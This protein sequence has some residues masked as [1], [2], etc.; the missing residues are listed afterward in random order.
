MRL[1]SHSQHQQQQQQQQTGS[2]VLS[3][4]ENPHRSAEHQENAVLP[5]EHYFGT[6]SPPPPVAGS[7]FTAGDTEVAEGEAFGQI[8]LMQHALTRPQPQSRQ[9]EHGAASSANLASRVFPAWQQQQ[10]MPAVQQSRAEVVVRKRRTRD[11]NFVTS[12][13]VFGRARSARTRASSKRKAS[14]RKASS[15]NT[16]RFTSSK[17]KRGN[18]RKPVEDDSDSSENSSSREKKRRVV[19]PTIPISLMNGYGSGVFP[20]PPG[21]VEQCGGVR[22]GFPIRLPGFRNNPG[23][24]YIPKTFPMLLFSFA[25]FHPDAFDTERGTMMSL[26]ILVEGDVDPATG[27]SEHYSCV[28]FHRKIFERVVQKLYK[29]VARLNMYI[30]EHKNAYVRSGHDINLADLEPEF[31]EEYNLSRESQAVLYALRPYICDYDRGEN[32]ASHESFARIFG[33]DVPSYA[34]KRSD[35]PRDYFVL[36]LA[37]VARLAVCS[38]GC[39]SF[40]IALQQMLPSQARTC[41]DPLLDTLNMSESFGVSEDEIR[42]LFVHDVNDLAKAA[43]QRHLSGRAVDGLHVRIFEPDQSAR[44]RTHAFRAPAYK[45][46]SDNTK[47]YNDNT[48]TFG[49]PLTQAQVRVVWD[50]AKCLGEICGSAH[51]SVHTRPTHIYGMLELYKREIPIED[52]K[53]VAY[54]STTA[55]NA[56]PF[57]QEPHTPARPIPLE[58]VNYLIDDS[59]LSKTNQ[60]GHILRARNR[61]RNKRKGFY[62]TVRDIDARCEVTNEQAVQIARAVLDSK[63]P[64]AAQLKRLI[65]M[66]AWIPEIHSA[67]VSSSTSASASAS[68][69]ASSS[70]NTK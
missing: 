2:P 53:D 43:V 62:N 57:C 17:S 54:L 5:A 7:Q 63:H 42:T 36:P 23:T 59:A 44:D 30:P 61:F 34:Y 52:S 3:Y 6:F 25:L 60:K 66:H 4:V 47:L 58:K 9:A 68:A 24:A 11:K 41:Y 28:A 70:S 21:L 26:P 55:L 38:P 67:V 10:T 15:R 27:R 69:S 31:A 37:I 18:Q 35:Y 56:Y 19:A 64:A 49:R 45:N 50:F 39:A 16:G 12:E 33:M 51:M 32:G 65:E 13:D 48:C 8:T 22:T 29:S 1:L 20:C 46:P 40:R 14:S